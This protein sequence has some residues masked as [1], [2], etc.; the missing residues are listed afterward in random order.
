MPL[1]DQPL[2]HTVTVVVCDVAGLDDPDLADV[3]TLARLRIVAHRAGWEFRLRGVSTELQELLELC[4]LCE[5]LRVEVGR[6]AEE[7]EET[8]SL[9]EEGDAGD[10]AV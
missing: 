9:E 1:N 10:P 3:E 2:P 8:G 4:G 7:R 6:Q 5:A